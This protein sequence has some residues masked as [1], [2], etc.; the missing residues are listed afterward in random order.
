MLAEALAAGE[1]ANQITGGNAEA[2]GTTGYILAK[3]GRTDDA[4]RLLADL[5]SRRDKPFL[6][7]A[8][9][10]VYLGLGDQERALQLLESAYKQRE[11]LMVFLKVE[12][13]WDELR[14]NSRFI[15]LMKQM[16]LE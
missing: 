2:T 9:A 3:L 4:R 1:R 10:Q 11:P 15:E 8:T 7:Y 16:N 13:K 12:P 6:A 14:T 5:Q